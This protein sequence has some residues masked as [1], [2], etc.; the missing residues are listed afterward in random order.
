MLY[1]LTGQKHSRLS[2]NQGGTEAQIVILSE[3]VLELTRHLKQHPRDYASIR[4]LKKILGQR[5]RLLKYLS[6]YDLAQYNQ[7]IQFM[8]EINV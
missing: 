3:R 5:R 6:K 2:K 4:G 8:K 1:Y 7:M